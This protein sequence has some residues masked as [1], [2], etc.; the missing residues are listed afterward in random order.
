L[1]EQL[2][3]ATDDRPFRFHRPDKRNERRKHP[4][5]GGLHGAM[6]FDIRRPFHG[7]SLRFRTRPF[8]HGRLTSVEPMILHDARRAFPDSI[9]FTSPDA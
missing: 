3:G 5:G 4:L 2:D 9:S 6:R 8:R 1:G 7:N